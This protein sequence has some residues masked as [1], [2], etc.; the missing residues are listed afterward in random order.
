MITS[1]MNTNKKYKYLLNAI[2]STNK[3]G[4]NQNLNASITFLNN[5]N[6]IDQQR[7]LDPFSP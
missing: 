6:N 4:N 7:I 3:R 1:I 2:L 5:D